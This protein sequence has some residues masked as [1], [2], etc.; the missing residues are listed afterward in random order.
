MEKK[1]GQV[2]SKSSTLKFT[3]DVWNPP[4]IGEK[5]LN[6]FKIYS[7]LTRQSNKFF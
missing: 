6:I 2:L 5:S 7:T 1:F 3:E 4:T